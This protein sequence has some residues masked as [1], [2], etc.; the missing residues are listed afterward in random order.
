ME[1]RNKN[2]YSFF[3]IKSEY[4]TFLSGATI[5]IPIALLLEMKDN[6]T[7]ISYWVAIVL[8]LFS[9]FSCYRLSILLSDIQSKIESK[10]QTLARTEAE[11][12]SVWIN[13]FSEFSSECSLLFFLTIVTFIASIV[14]LVIMQF[15]P[16]STLSP[17]IV[18]NIV[19]G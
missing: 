18:K 15:M 9:S 16:T 4:F 7:R 11:R 14:F 2:K 19:K 3:R 17:E 1:K 8:A 10:C 6:Y 5:S 12:D 13:A